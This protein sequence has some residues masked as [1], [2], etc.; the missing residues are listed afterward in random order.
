MKEVGG[1]RSKEPE[2]ICEGGGGGG[3]FILVQPVIH[4]G[5]PI[6]SRRS[7]GVDEGKKTF[8]GKQQ[9]GGRKKI[10]T[11][12]RTGPKIISCERILTREKKGAEKTG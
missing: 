3:G 12:G 6:K 2:Q 8:Q 10:E 9:Q 11:N 4:W 7:K 1:T 5:G